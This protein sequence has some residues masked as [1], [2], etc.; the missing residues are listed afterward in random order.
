MPKPCGHDTPVCNCSVC[1]TF[2]LRKDYR[3]L[4]S[5]APIEEVWAASLEISKK[6]GKPPVFSK[7][8]EIPEA[9]QNITPSKCIH[10]GITVANLGGCR[11]TYECESGHGKVRACVECRSC[12]DFVADDMV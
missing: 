4:W 8:G 5:D 6:T 12:K 11:T 2:M 10:L 3:F 1:E 7:P 9:L